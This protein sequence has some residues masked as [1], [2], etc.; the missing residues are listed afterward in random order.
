M[1]MTAAMAPGT[2]AALG[3]ASAAVLSGLSA[4]MAGQANGN[5]S[6]GPDAGIAERAPG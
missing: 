4:A 5:A 1:T 6:R 3:A 2:S